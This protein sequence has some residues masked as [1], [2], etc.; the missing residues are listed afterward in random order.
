MGV[1]ALRA[2]W[3]TFEEVYDEHF[4]FVWRSVRRL[5]VA[6]AQ[7]DDAVQ[8]VFVVVHRRFATWEGKG[9]L[10][11]WI[12]GIARRVVADHR[13][14]ARRKPGAGVVGG[15]ED[16]SIEVVDGS[17]GP[18]EQAALSEAARTLAELLGAMDEEKREVFM[19]ADLEG[20]PAPEIADAL[21]TNVNTVYSRLRAARAWFEKELARRAR[22]AK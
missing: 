11:S 3:V 6:E 21:E 16:L 19:L 7:V 20:M 18:F 15:A 2:S 1:V 13:R 12:F 4:A 14:T 17:P 22:G 9:A 10:R 5:G 8:E